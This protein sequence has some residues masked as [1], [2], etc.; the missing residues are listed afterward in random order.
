[1]ANNNRRR[2]KGGSGRQAS[3]GQPVLKQRAK[4]PQCSGPAPHVAPETPDKN[5]NAGPPNEG[6]RSS[7]VDIS[8]LLN[9]TAPTAASAAAIDEPPPP[10]QK[11]E[12]EK[13]GEIGRHRESVISVKIPETDGKTNDNPETKKK[14]KPRKKKNGDPV[15]KK[16]TP[17]HLILKKPNGKEEGGSQQSISRASG[18]VEG[19]PEHLMSSGWKEIVAENR[20]STGDRKGVKVGKKKDVLI[21]Q[22]GSNNGSL[23]KPEVEKRVSA[24]EL[25]S[26]QRSLEEAQRN[27]VK[28]RDTVSILQNKVNG[29]NDELDAIREEVAGS[30]GNFC[31]TQLKDEIRSLQES[32]LME[33]RKTKSLEKQL[34][35]ER[36]ASSN[37]KFD[38][39]SAGSEEELLKEIDSL[40]KK[41]QSERAEKIALKMES[42]LR[43]STGALSKDA[44][45]QKLLS[46]ECAALK[47][48]L[49]AAN[50][51]MRSF[52]VDSTK[53]EALNIAERSVETKSDDVTNVD[54]EK[55]DLIKVLRR[56]LQ[57][58]RLK[59]RQERKK[60]AAAHHQL[61]QKPS[62]SMQRSRAAATRQPQFSVAPTNGQQL[63]NGLIPIIQTN[64]AASSI[65]MP[66]SRVETSLPGST[67][68]ETARSE[69]DLPTDENECSAAP[70]VVTAS[71]LFNHD[72]TEV[73]YSNDLLDDELV[74]LRSAY[75]QEEI[76][77]V[78]NRVTHLLDLE[79]EPDGGIVTIA[80][81]CTI[82]HYY[83]SRGILDVTATVRESD[84]AANIAKCA[85][86]CLPELVELCRMEAKANEGDNAINSVFC[87]AQG[88]AA[89]DWYN[90]LSRE[91]SL[92][93]NEDGSQSPQDVGGGTKIC[94]VLLQ[95][96]HLVENETDKIQSVKKNASKL[97]LGG[98]I[99]TGKPGL[100]LVEG[101][102][103]D[104]D[105]FADALNHSKKVFRLSSFKTVGKSV[106]NAKDKMLPKKLEQLDSGKG[107]LEQIT[108]LCED[109]G[110][111]QELGLASIPG[112]VRVVLGVEEAHGVAV[113][114]EGM[115]G[116]VS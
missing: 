88:Y 17:K 71:S 61:K 56:S 43:T 109:L 66:R 92:S 111:G 87:V 28:E 25:M 13:I 52:S 97:S 47:M 103:H 77:F 3:G 38:R 18:K 12:P 20:N 29:L 54:T 108:E 69:P 115:C 46:A 79:S 21:L 76:E 99:R 34:E 19:G 113:P 68:T 62:Q 8:L 114:V 27:L 2:K 32:L 102:E 44:E 65:N 59:L 82:P 64:S 58:E 55:D 33:H 83:P 67:I 36:R 90:H 75:D 53:S 78:E 81:T 93:K 73:D 45:K 37:L 5:G 10:V 74:F 104:C 7:G 42:S 48:E 85:M 11:T 15:A 86:N 50:S 31:V 24:T 116:W 95:T 22:R 105:Q 49:L 101:T 1:M 98:Y 94:A 35:R 110:L 112:A 80:L 51:R 39:N 9:S 57:Q 16:G 40:K 91:L 84:C 4:D 96:H 70:P 26:L 60:L 100:V 63:A 41:V 23:K 72:E 14:K 30:D 106:R 6:C 89:V 107:G